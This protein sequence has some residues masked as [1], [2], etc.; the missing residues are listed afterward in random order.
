MS[1]VFL[2]RNEPKFDWPCDRRDAHHAHNA[3]KDSSPSEWCPV[4]GVERGQSH[5]R[6]DCDGS[7]PGVG[8]HPATMAGGSYASERPQ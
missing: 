4:C 2:V 3:Y 5:A 7:C 1:E 8:A 6:G